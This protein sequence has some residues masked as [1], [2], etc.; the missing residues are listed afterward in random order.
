MQKPRFDRRAYQR[1][2]AKGSVKVYFRDEAEKR[3]FMAMADADGFGNFSQWV[4]QR[5]LAASTGHVYPAGYVEDLQKQVER[6][7]AW[8]EQKDAEI[9]ELRK[10][11]RTVNQ[12]REDL[13]VLVAELG[14]QPLQ[15][16]PGGAIR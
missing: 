8:L 6:Y 16:P 9:A 12:Q 3:E 10:D 4:I 7:R 5:L 11:L 13:R 14:R 15:R 1:E 2:R